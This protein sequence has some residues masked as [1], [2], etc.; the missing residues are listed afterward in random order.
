MGRTLREVV[1]TGNPKAAG[2]RR[3]IF[4]LRCHLRILFDARTRNIASASSVEKIA[5]ETSH[6]TAKKEAE[7]YAIEKRLSP[8]TT[9]LVKTA[10]SHKNVSLGSI[11]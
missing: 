11:A 1:T 3:M 6:L 9:D 4:I 8:E 2:L 5:A 10:R 7:F